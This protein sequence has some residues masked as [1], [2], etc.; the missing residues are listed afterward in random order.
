MKVYITMFDGWWS[1]S[2]REFR[3]QLDKWEES[4]AFGVDEEL[5]TELT[6]RP[7]CIRGSTK[8]ERYGDIR[9][10]P[11][12]DHLVFQPLLWDGFAEEFVKRARRQ[13]KAAMDDNEEVVNGEVRDSY[14]GWQRKVEERG[15][16]QLFYDDD[17]DEDLLVDDEEYLD[18]KSMCRRGHHDWRMNG[19]H[20]EYGE[21]V[22]RFVCRRCGAK[23]KTSEIEVVIEGDTSQS[24]LRETEEHQ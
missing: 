12:S 11:G 17:V 4:G 18:R 21:T 1:Y 5:S 14:K 10:A 15:G 6:S 24:P 23:G 22:R 2:I 20:E 13:I 19:T 9:T 3:E 8:T 16:E 7:S